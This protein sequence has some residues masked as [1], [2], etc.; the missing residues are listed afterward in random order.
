MRIV[1]FMAQTVNG[2]IAHQNGETPWSEQTFADYYELSKRFPALIVG[3]TTFEMMSEFNEFEKIGN[4]LVIVLSSA[5]G[6]LDEKVVFVQTPQEAITQLKGRD[7][8][9]AMLGGG[10]TTNTAF[11][12]AGLVDELIIDVEP[13]LFGHGIPFLKHDTPSLQL[14]LLGCEQRE[15]NVRLRYKVQK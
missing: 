9:Q 15:Q 5:S 11:L 7:I 1:L 6:V 3:R 4:P 13:Q 12:E 2:F 8:T 10:A 14:E